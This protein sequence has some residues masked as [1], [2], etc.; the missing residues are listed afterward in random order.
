MSDLENLINQQI[1]D[2]DLF[3]DHIF[4]EKG[5]QNTLNIVLD[6][7]NII[8]VDKIVTVSKIISPIVDKY[9]FTSDS[10]VL[11]IYSKEKGD[12]KDE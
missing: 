12:K 1:K 4:Y 6:S 5:K 8:N 9:N 2:Y 3:V 10:Y 7:K 11:D